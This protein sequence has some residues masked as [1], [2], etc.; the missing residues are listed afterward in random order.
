MR[1][2]DLLSS[3]EVTTTSILIFIATAVTSI[4]TAARAINNFDKKID[5]CV[6]LCDVAH[7]RIERI[8]DNIDKLRDNIDLL[9]NK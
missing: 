3:V 5:R 1:L 2:S 6:Y 8:E 9:H 4:F 7:E